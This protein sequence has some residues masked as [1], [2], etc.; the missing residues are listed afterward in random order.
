MIY[1][2][3]AY[4]AYNQK[5]KEKYESTDPLEKAE[6]QMSEGLW[7]K[8][9]ASVSDTQEAEVSIRVACLEKES[10]QPMVDGCMGVGTNSVH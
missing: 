10:C 9:Q 6:L 3:C 7:R 5:R 8:E 2:A 1:Y 4:G